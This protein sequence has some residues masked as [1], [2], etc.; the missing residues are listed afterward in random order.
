MFNDFIISQMLLEVTKCWHTA[1]AR[2][3]IDLN[4]KGLDDPKGVKGY[5]TKYYC[6]Y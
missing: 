3:D 5:D 1:G 4:H 2:A 6:Y